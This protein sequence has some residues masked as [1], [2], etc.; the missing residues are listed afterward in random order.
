MKPTGSLREDP[1]K[2]RELAGWYREFAE[3]AGNPAIWEARQIIPHLGIFHRVLDRC[4]C[5]S[6]GRA[7]LRGNGECVAEAGSRPRHPRTY[8]RLRTAK[9]LE[10]K[11]DRLE[12]MA[13]RGLVRSSNGAR[14]TIDRLTDHRDE[15]SVAAR[16]LRLGKET[17]FSCYGL[18][19][20]PMSRW[21]SRSVWFPDPLAVLRFR[22]LNDR[23]NSHSI[24]EWA[25]LHFFTRPPAFTKNCT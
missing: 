4:D 24:L 25:D 9:D 15:M 13:A 16:V 8:T 3:Q 6:A 21:V 22:N 1:R 20:T 18:A 5:M 23:D 11:A 12:K 7:R 19:N 17:I 2:L 10:R 14:Q